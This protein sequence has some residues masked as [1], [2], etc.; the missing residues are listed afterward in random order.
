LLKLIAA[1]YDKTTGFVSLEN[2]LGAFFPE[3]TGAAGDEN[4][5]VV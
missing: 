4:G 5:F 1:K 3:R 2:Y